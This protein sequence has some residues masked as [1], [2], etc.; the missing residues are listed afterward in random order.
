MSR[1]PLAPGPLGVLLLAAAAGAAAAGATPAP[2]AAQSWATIQF[3]RQHLD[4]EELQ[5]RVRY[6]AGRFSVA[7]SE[8]SHL[9]RVRLRYDEEAFEPIHEY[10]DGRLV[11][12]VEGTARQRVTR[13]A[14]RAGEMDLQLTTRVPVDLHLEF[15]AVRSEMDLGGLRLTRLDLTTGASDSELR[16]SEPNPGE[17]ERARFQVGAAS[18]SARDLGRL[19]AREISVEA[20][21]GDVRLDLAGLIREE[22]RV[23]AKMGLGSLEI[24]IPQGV[25]IRLERSTFLTSLTA[26]DLTRRGD[27]YYSADWDEAERRVVVEV[28]AIFGSV[29]IL[30]SGR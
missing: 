27:H 8:T 15:G 16:V 6:G 28:E 22:T 3:S 12:G 30:R 7:P 18:F 24:R 5:V 21:V 11:V 1:P 4:Q 14:D 23:Q 25:G 17:M 2:A 9:Y 26:P 19:N 20:G 10:R 13:R 29:S